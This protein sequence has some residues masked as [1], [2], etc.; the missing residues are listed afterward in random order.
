MAK[1]DVVCPRCSETSDVIRNGH[2][3]S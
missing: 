1:I 2:S 3:T